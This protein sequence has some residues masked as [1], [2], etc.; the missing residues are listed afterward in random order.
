MMIESTS[1]S[2]IGGGEG[3]MLDESSSSLRTSLPLFLESESKVTMEMGILVAAVETD[4]V[5]SLQ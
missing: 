5:R 2:R 4:T 1:K 3:G